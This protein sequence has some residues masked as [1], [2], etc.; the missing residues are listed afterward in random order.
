MK[1]NFTKLLVSCF[2]ILLG[3]GVNAQTQN[4]SVGISHSYTVAPENA[5]N[6][7]AWS[8]TGVENTDWEVASGALNTAAVE[9]RWKKPGTYTMQFTE[10]ESHTGVDCSTTVQLTVI[11]AND[12]DVV[13]ADAATA[14]SCATGSTGNTDVTFTLTKTNGSNSWT[15]DYTTI[16]LATEITGNDI[17]ATGNTHDLTI[18][19][20]N[21]ADGSDQ[22]FKVQISDVKDS[23]GN[24]STTGDD[25]T[26][27]VTIYG[28][29]NTGSIT[30]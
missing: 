7:L 2:F 26:A 18:S 15:F 5:G 4:L 8:I 20:T 30:F 13:I 1:T 22:T 29:P 17:A 16:G 25:D 24:L 3:Y 27:N 10:T 12:F 21:T 19:L 14:A 6:T 23:F 11:V 9:I 28:V